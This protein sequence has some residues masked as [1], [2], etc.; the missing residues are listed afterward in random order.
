[1]SVTAVSSD[2]LTITRLQPYSSILIGVD[3]SDHPAMASRMPLVLL[4]S[5][6]PA[7]RG[8]ACTS[9]AN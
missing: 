5:G 6:N 8:F 9:Q 1:M 3:A 2:Q 7:F 4:K